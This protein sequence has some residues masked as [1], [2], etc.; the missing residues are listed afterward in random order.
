MAEQEVVTS[1]RLRKFV[2]ESITNGAKR[3]PKSIKIETSVITR[4]SISLIG[5]LVHQEKIGAYLVP[6]NLPGNAA[7]MYVGDNDK[8][9]GNS[10]FLSAEA[11]KAHAWEVRGVLLHEAVHAVNDLI[12][13][14]I[15]SLKD[16]ALAHVVEIL[17]HMKNGVEPLKEPYITARLAALEVLSDGKVSDATFKKLKIVLSRGA[18]GYVKEMRHYNG[19]P[20]TGVKTRKSFRREMKQS[21]NQIKPK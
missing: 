20:G 7:A 10:I 8:D 1:K 14:S 11:V 2:A 12:G 17:F 21:T 4:E 15:G 5:A 9:W 18:N 6:G 3:L 13:K 16:E 19:I